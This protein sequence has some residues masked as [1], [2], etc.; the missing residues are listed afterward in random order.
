MVYCTKCGTKNE[1]DAV[2]CVKCGV[3]LQAGGRPSR[4]YG[5]R[6]HDEECFGI[7]QGGT[8]VGLIIGIII[9]IAGVSWLLDYQF[10]DYLWPLLVIVFGL[11]IVVG[12]LYKY[13][14]S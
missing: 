12:A 5:R 13:G 1:D 4:R 11:L 2:V 3:N 14:R 9:I 7:P 8:I 6:R 10:W